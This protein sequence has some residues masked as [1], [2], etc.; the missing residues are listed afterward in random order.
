MIQKT[1]FAALFIFMQLSSLPAQAAAP[2]DS[3]SIK[4]GQMLMIGFRGLT[5]KAPGIADDIRKRHI[6]GVVLFDYD[7][8]LKSP[9]RNIAGPEQLSKLTRELMDLS[10]IPLF[11]ALDQ[12][13][14]KVNRLKTSKGFPPSVSAAHLGMLDNPDSTTA[15]AR[16]TAATLKKMHLNMNL[17]PVL[18]LN[19]NSENPV[20]GKLGRSYSA[21]PAVVT[22]HAGLT[23]RVF[24]EEGIIPVF[25]HFPGHGSSTTDSHKGFTDVTASW[26][27]K[28]IEPYRSLI[29]AGY[30]D[31]VMTA[32]VF[33][34]QLDDRYPATLSQKVLNDRLRSRLRFDGVI[35]SDDMQM[36]A[37][38]DQFGLEDAI[39]LALDAGVD[40]LIFGNNTTFDP[41]I[42]EKATAILHELVQNGTV[43]RARID[44]SYRRIMALKERY[45]YHC[46]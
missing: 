45:L 3:L 6:G 12:E 8:P 35:L 10:E 44:R 20:I 31:A 29:A 17:A 46:K 7:V 19:T 21:D 40:I 15:A 30:D 13:G 5:A 18:D 26:T 39:R 9:V 11:I 28:E 24:R 41:A 1:L 37:I 16:Q 22:R 27:E 2:V 25:K 23:A 36:K 4:I 32:H 14:G 33:N 34:R 42:A 38:A 43:S